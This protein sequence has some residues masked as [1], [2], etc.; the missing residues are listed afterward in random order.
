MKRGNITMRLHAQRE[1]LAPNIELRRKYIE[2]S[3]HSQL[4]VEKDIIEGH[5][6]R[7]PY[8]ARRVFLAG[9]LRKLN[10]QLKK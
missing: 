4:R 7:L 3:Y 5:I 10:A 1:R 6:G 8:G 9:R 2:A